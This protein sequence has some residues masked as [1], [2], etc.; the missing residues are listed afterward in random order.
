M[1]ANDIQTIICKKNLCI[2]KVAE[3]KS[4][5]ESTLS[6]ASHVVV[7]VSQIEKIDTAALQLFIALYK[8]AGAGDFTLEFKQPSEI[9]CAAAQRL[10]LGELLTKQDNS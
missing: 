7:D 2:A 6:L 10:G 4:E 3:F 1:D 9:F 8:Q 5:L